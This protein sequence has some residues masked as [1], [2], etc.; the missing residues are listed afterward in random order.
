MTSSSV[1]HNQSQ[2]RTPARVWTGRIL[3]GLAIAFMLFDGL[4]KLPEP[5]PVRQGMAQLGY[6]EHL[7]EYIG[8]IALVCT[9]LY[10]IPRTA[11]IGAVLLTGYLGGAVASQVRVQAV[12]FNIAFPFILAAFVWGGLYLRDARVRAVVRGR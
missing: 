4:Y 8:V 11:A 10:A 6:P 7:A 2:V 3:S 9:I 1:Q 5:T 12:A